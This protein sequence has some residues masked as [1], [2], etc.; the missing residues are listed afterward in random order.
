MSKSRN[1][2]KRNLYLSKQEKLF[3]LRDYISELSTDEVE[4]LLNVEC[5]HKVKFEQKINLF[6]GSKYRK[7]LDEQIQ[8]EYKA[9]QD[10]FND[11]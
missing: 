7:M 4:E 10:I 6:I 8:F 11:L 5:K 2:R 9:Y 1:K 3:V